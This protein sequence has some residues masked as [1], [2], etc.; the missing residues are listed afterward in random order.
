VARL[1]DMGIE[2]FLLASTLNFV[3]G[4]RLVRRICMKCRQSVTADSR[5]SDVLRARPDFD[6]TVAMLRKEGVLGPGDD[7]MAGLRMFTGN[8]CR[9]CHGT[10][11]SGRLGIYEAFEV[12]REAHAMIM[13]R[14]DGASVRASA[15]ARGMKTMFQDGLA[16][17]LLGQTTLE[18]VFRVAQ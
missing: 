5:L 1:L 3:V 7:P 9:Q 4:Q 11:Y 6:G 2:P 8:G 15:I 17:V 18:E 16:K 12:D 10:G 13:A 14:A